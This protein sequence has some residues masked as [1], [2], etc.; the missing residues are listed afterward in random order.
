MRTGGGGEPP[1]LTPQRPAYGPTS[2][3]PHRGL[4]QAQ[5]ERGAQRSARRDWG[6]RVQ[7]DKPTGGVA[8]AVCPS[9]P[10]K[11]D[12]DLDC[13]C[14]LG[15]ASRPGRQPITSRFCLR[16]QA[17]AGGVGPCFRLTG[18]GERRRRRSSSPPVRCACKAFSAFHRHCRRRRQCQDGVLR[19]LFISSHSPVFGEDRSPQVLHMLLTQYSVL[20]TVLRS[21]FCP[22]DKGIRT[23]AV[24]G[25]RRS[26]RGHGD[27]N[28]RPSWVERRSPFFAWMPSR[29]HR[30]RSE[31]AAVC[32]GQFL[33]KCLF[34]AA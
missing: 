20:R 28:G 33:E 7:T 26:P 31:S 15:R 9:Q 30:R 17:D 2:L 19:M 21:T 6:G 25:E 32:P 1:R 27:A 22:P 24:D 8:A 12:T 4:S 34:S 11:G 23:R 18:T 13:L 14:N 10:E 5:A 29:R 16:S 3:P